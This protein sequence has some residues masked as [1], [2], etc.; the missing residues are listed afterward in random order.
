MAITDVYL[1]AGADVRIPGRGVT[2]ILLFP[3][4]PD[5]SGDITPPTLTI[6]INPSR[7]K[8]SSFP[9]K[10]VAT[11]SFAVDEPYAAYE[12]RLVDAESTPREQGTLFESGSGG[13]ANTNREVDITYSEWTAAGISEGQFRFKIFVRDITGNWSL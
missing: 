8:I 9:D 5:V 2:D 1:R 6:T 7:T 12:I 3:Q 10:D 13:P 4:G 11:V